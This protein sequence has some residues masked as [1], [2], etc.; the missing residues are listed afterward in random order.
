MF[1]RFGI[2]DSRIGHILSNPTVQLLG[3]TS[4]SRFCS[5]SFNCRILK[6]RR[7]PV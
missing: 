5:S 7:V 3:A 6:P 2:F 1:S 4:E